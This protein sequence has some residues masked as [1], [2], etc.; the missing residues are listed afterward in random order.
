MSSTEHERFGDGGQST[1]SG[2]LPWTRGL[3]APRRRAIDR[4]A[5]WAKRAWGYRKAALMH[6]SNLIALASLLMLGLIHP[7]AAIV[8]FGLGA[9]LV[10][11]CLAPRSEW[12]RR[13][14][15]EGFED[16]AQACARR[17]RQAL[18]AKMADGHRDELVRIEG[19]IQKIHEIEAG[20]TEPVPFAEELDL[21]RVPASYIRL[22]LAHKACED[23]L[24]LVEQ[25]P[26]RIVIRSLEAAQTTATERVR[27]AIRERLSIAYQRAEHE[28]Q[29][30]ESLEAIGHQL[31]ALV[32][33]VHLRHQRAITLGPSAEAASFMQDLEEARSAA[34]EIGELDAAERLPIKSSAFA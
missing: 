32:D 5:P 15:D 31:A 18:I 21:S 7:S 10:F 2:A 17:A 29:V 33:L 16:A 13:C 24:S 11:F 8:L 19:L 3:A 26:T 27:A 20:R 28:A 30:R 25:K 14:L 22:A 34:R 12:L 9:E 1:D 6:P 23:A 4:R